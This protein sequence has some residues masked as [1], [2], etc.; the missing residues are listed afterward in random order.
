MPKD[1]G[2]K[3]TKKPK[4]DKNSDAGKKQKDPNKHGFDSLN[5]KK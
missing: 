3:E 2:S 1:K 5:D 4:K